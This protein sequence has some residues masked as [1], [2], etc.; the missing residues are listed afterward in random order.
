MATTTQKSTTPAPKAP[1]PAPKPAV[2][3]YTGSATQKAQLDAAAAKGA[4]QTAADKANLAY[5]ATKGY[6]P[7]AAGPS[8]GGSGSV[9]KPTDVTTSPVEYN[10]D[11]TRKSTDSQ[12]AQYWQKNPME[13]NE[14]YNARIAQLKAENAARQKTAIDS[15]ES[16]YTSILNSVALDNQNATN[17]TEAINSLNGLRGGNIGQ[18]NT[19]RT[20]GANQAA[21]EGK[22]AEKASK[23]QSIIQTFDAQLQ[24]EIQF[25]TNLRETDRSKYLDY[26]ASPLGPDAT[27]AAL[28]DNVRKALLAS[29]IAPKDISEDQWKQ[30]AEGSGMDL[31]QFKSLYV[32]QWKVNEEQVTAAAQKAADERAKLLAE[33]AKLASDANGGETAK[34][35]MAKGFQYIASP[36]ELKKLVSQGYDPVNDFVRLPNGKIF[37]NPENALTLNRKAAIAKKYSGGGGGSEK[38]YTASTIPPDLNTEILTRIAENSSKPIDQQ[39]TYADLATTYS[40]VDSNYLGQLWQNSR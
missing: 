33:T 40:D 35:L 12:L 25:Q 18:A 22:L 27:K 39:M 37:L 19:Q 38:R 36:D 24:D 10:P 28:G 8:G 17:S 32:S 9:A 16:M 5:A 30:M 7:P 20:A 21:I 29:R 23:I 31:N 4:N 13:S 1:A 26:L 3:S 11:G 2:P 34:A 14:A 15:V 6:T